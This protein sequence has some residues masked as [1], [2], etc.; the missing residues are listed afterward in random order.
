MFGALR[1]DSQCKDD[2]APVSSVPVCFA[3]LEDD[4]DIDLT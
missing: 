3:I 2:Q 1:G 4:L